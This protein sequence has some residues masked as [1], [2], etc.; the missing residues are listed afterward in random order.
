LLF[1]RDRRAWK[2]EHAAGHAAEHPQAAGES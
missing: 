1:V 2:A